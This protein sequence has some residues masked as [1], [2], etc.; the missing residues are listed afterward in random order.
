MKEYKAEI[1][2]IN[3]NI[4]NI[5]KIIKALNIRIRS[6]DGNAELIKEKENNEAQQKTH[7][8]KKE[9]IDKKLERHTEL[10]VELKTCKSSIK[11]IK[12]QKEQKLQ[13]AKDNISPDEALVLILEKWQT[14]TSK[15]Q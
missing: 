5:K 14:Q 9:A 10:Q 13:E 2:V 4:K 6:N 7:E 15:Q 3:G 12:D 11:E 1:K 8:S